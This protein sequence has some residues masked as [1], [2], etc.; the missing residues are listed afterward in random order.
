MKL[1][2][3]LLIIVL[4]AFI[5]CDDL[6]ELEPK[7]EIIASEALKTPQ[8]MQDLLNSAYDALRGT[9]GD[10]L[11]GRVQSIA[12]VMGDNI[13]GS[14]TNLNNAD[15]RAYYNKTST[16]FTGYT[17]AMF[18]EPHFVIYRAN[19]LLQNLDIL[20]GS[21]DA[22]RIEGEAKFLRALC[23][24]ELVRLFA[25]PYGYTPDNTHLGVVLRTDPN[26]EATD[27]HNVGQVYE[28]IAQDLNDASTLL[29][30]TNDVYADSWAAKAYLAKVNFHMHDFQ[31][32]FD[33]AT[34]VIENGPYAFNTST[35]EYNDRYSTTRSQEAIFYMISNVNDNRG[36]QFLTHF[37]SDAADPPTL[38]INRELYDIATA[39]AADIRVNWYSLINE[40]AENE[41]VF[42]TKFDG[43]NYLN[44]PLMHTTEM[45]LIRAEAGAE[46]NQAETLTTA[47][48][49]IND[50]RARAGLNA[51]STS[52]GQS[53]L[54]NTIQLEKRLELVG[55]G[56]RFHDLRRRGANGE[57][58]LQIRNSDW[59]CP[60]M[61]IQ[62][63]DTE[64]AGAG[65]TDTFTPNQEGGC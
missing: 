53:T 10:F 1:S 26:A 11:G 52:I 3:Y 56:H 13:D 17:Q 49:D 28:Q 46:I 34:D 19:V 48:A 21:A 45:K 47:I 8:D 16:F 9:G 27:R 29:P 36:P 55:E 62:F 7:G 61:S 60:G 12:E 40:G 18:K 39:D 58:S 44:V 63:P 30:T 43:D 14:Q 31:A 20:E 50:I 5:S 22:S 64:I 41:A 54:L 38:K 32:A 35:D 33:L 25:Q 24:F 6:L 15:F 59:D 37:R 2:K 4:T 42:V 51:L 57:T 65:G 23:Y